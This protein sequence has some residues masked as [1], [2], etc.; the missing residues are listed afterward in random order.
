MTPPPPAGSSPEKLQRRLDEEVV[1]RSS[2]LSC[3]AGL[4][5]LVLLVVVVHAWRPNYVVQVSELLDVDSF[6]CVLCA[7]PRQGDSHVAVEGI[8]VETSYKVVVACKGGEGEA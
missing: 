1:N 3:R 4:G 7:G 6:R 2:E 8:A 5:V